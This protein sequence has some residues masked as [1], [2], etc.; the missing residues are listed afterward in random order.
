MKIRLQR[1]CLRDTKFGGSGQIVPQREGMGLVTSLGGGTSVLLSLGTAD[2]SLNK[3][4][5]S[6]Q[7]FGWGPPMTVQND[8]DHHSDYGPAQLALFG[9]AAIVLLVLT[10]LT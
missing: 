6:R 1:R 2:P 5:V 8:H 9:A 3:W 7:S 4:I 10:F